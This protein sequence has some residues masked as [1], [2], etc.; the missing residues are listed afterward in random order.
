MEGFEAASVLLPTDSGLGYK[1]TAP[2]PAAAVPPP[3]VASSLTD[4]DDTAAL[5]AARAERRKR[6]IEA[7]SLPRSKNDIAEFMSSDANAGDID[8]AAAAAGGANNNTGV[9]LSLR[10]QLLRNAQLK[11]EE[12]ES[13]HNP[14]RAPEGLSEEDY[15][16]YTD[17]LNARLSKYALHKEQEKREFEEFQLA[18]MKREQEEKEREIAVGD[19]KLQPLEQLD[20]ELSFSRLAAAD[21]NTTKATVASIPAEVIFPALAPISMPI[22]TTLSTLPPLVLKRKH[23]E[24]KSKGKDSAHKRKK[25]RKSIDETAPTATAAKVSSP[26]TTTTAPAKHSADIKQASSSSTIGDATAE[27]GDS[28]GGSNNALLGLVAYSSDDD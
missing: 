28:G 1:E 19:R 8:S 15:A 26:A 18:R 14:F 13:K 7:L 11:Q 20:P 23:S 17:S 21:V 12:Y 6:E 10:D 4:L 25:H 24:D 27:P 22:S 2:L 3:P 9:R 5:A 16:V